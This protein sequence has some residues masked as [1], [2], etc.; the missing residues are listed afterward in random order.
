[1]SNAERIE[2]IRDALQHS[3]A[4]VQLQ[5]EDDSHRHAGHAGA[6]D[7]RGHFNVRVVSGAFAGLGQLARHRAIYAALGDMM[8]TDIH[9]LSIQAHTPAEAG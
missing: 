4:P 2:R 7:G 9:A 5:I 6:R 8:Q 1:M 3:L